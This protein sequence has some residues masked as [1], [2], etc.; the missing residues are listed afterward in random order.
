ML[1][2]VVHMRSGIPLQRFPP[3]SRKHNGHGVVPYADPDP[4]ASEAFGGHESCGAASEWV[5]Y[6]ITFIRARADHPLIE[7]KPLLCR[8]SGTFRIVRLQSTDV[9]PKRI[10]WYLCTLLSTP[11]TCTN[12]FHDEPIE[13]RIGQEIPQTWCQG[14]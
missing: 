13:Q 3:H 6:E 9:V 11:Q 8:V 10:K 1:P 7:R 4:P 12:T 5:K 2:L 14:L